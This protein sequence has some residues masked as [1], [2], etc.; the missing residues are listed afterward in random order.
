MHTGM[1]DKNTSTCL[2]SRPNCLKSRLPLSRVSRVT[3]VYITR[4]LS[5]IDVGRLAPPIVIR[6]I[7]AARSPAPKESSC[8]SP[9]STESSSRRGRSVCGTGLSAS[10][11]A[12]TLQVA[13]P[14]DRTAA[15]RAFRTARASVALKAKQRGRAV[16]STFALPKKL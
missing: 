11:A 7:I 13:E 15:T 3:T 16:L 2:L 5:G 4:V 1:L 9:M 14:G 8:T 6:S 12:Q 10:I